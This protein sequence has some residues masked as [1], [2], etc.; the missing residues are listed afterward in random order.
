M[1]MV[2]GTEVEVDDE[3]EVVDAVV[4]VDAVEVVASVVEVDAAVEL[5]V[6]VRLVSVPPVVVGDSVVDVVEVDSVVEVVPAPVLDMDVVEPGSFDV[7]V[8]AGIAYNESTGPS[9]GSSGDEPVSHA[10]PS[11]S[12]SRLSR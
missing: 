6:V 7:D 1:V 4:V 5:E 8:V 2:V 11:L 9:P 10:T 12:A 3:D